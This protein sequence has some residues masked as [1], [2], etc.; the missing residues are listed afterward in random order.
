MPR[1]D[2][3]R[4]PHHGARPPGAQVH[5]DPSV[6]GDTVEPQADAEPSTRHAQPHALEPCGE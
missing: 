5:G 6:V 4:A 1:L 3:R 2:R